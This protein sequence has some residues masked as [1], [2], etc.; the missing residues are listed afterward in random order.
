MAPG[1]PQADCSTALAAPMCQCRQDNYI[2]KA[3]GMIMPMQVKL[4]LVTM[5]EIIIFRILDMP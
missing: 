1:P 2:L 5:R 3:L 4:D